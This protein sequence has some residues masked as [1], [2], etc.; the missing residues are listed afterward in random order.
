[1]PKYSSIE[2]RF[3][4]HNSVPA[5]NK[6]HV[7]RIKKNG[8]QFVWRYRED[9]SSSVQTV[10]MTREEVFT[11]LDTLMGV[12]AWD[13]QPYKYVQ[14][15]QPALPSVL[16]HAAHVAWNLP[17]FKASLA[18]TFDNWPE[19]MTVSE[20][21]AAAGD[22]V[23]E[24]VDDAA[25]DEDDDAE[26]DDDDDAEDEDADDDVEDDDAEYADMP[27]L[28]AYDEVQGLPGRPCGYSTPVRSCTERSCPPAPSRVSDP[29]AL[30]TRS[31][32]CC[33][34]VTRAFEEA[35][36]GARVHTYFS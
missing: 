24:D 35:D 5:D 7:V 18:L 26:D 28:V 17:A 34:N 3:I 27:P 33:S 29:P 8:S 21:T 10:R 6:D 12:L 15:T 36:D 13:A 22:D 20:A 19:N 31:R 2:I 1:M 14:L 4:H 9:H 32:R 16:F 30:N 23:M 25:E 11:H